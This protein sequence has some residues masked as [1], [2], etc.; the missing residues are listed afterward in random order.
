V[1]SAVSRAFGRMPGMAAPSLPRDL[2]L[3][4]I[5]QR[6]PA[7]GNNRPPHSGSLDRR[8]AGMDNQFV[9]RD[10]GVP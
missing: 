7:D 10:R 1:P 9:L 2:I 3:P 4:W 6:T 8:R 5:M